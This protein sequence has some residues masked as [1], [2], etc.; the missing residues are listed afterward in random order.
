VSKKWTFHI[1]RA[2]LLLFILLL[3]FIGPSAVEPDELSRD[4]LSILEP[5][6]S[7][8]APPTAIS[9]DELERMEEALEA[10]R[11]LVQTHPAPEISHDLNEL[12]ETRQVYL[13]LQDHVVGS[14]QNIASARYINT[15][16]G[17]HLTLVVSPR[18]LLDPDI[19]HE[20]KQL[21]IYHE[22]IHI[23]QQLT[24]STPSWLAIGV[25]PETLTDDEIRIF[26]DAEMEAYVAECRLAERIHAIQSF[27]LCVIYGNGGLS[28]MRAAYSRILAASPGYAR[29]SE[30]VIR[31]GTEF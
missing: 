16:Q 1:L 28:A 17:V 7:S 25:P 23:R 4:A 12:V 10:L 31:I 3:A 15:P 21:V 30:R 26:I 22:Y 18:L 29:V 9:Q 11:V 5:E 14:D 20:F 24:G 27:E 2:V 8:N 6:P 13:N 19:S